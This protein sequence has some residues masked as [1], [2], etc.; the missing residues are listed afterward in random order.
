MLV[1]V[2]VRGDQVSSIDRAVDD[3]FTLFPAADGADFFAFGGTE[4][5]SFSFFADWAGHGF[6]FR[7]DEQ[8]TPYGVKNTNVASIAVPCSFVGAGLAP[9]GRRILSR[10]H[11]L[12]RR[13]N[14][15]VPL[16][17][18]SFSST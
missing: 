12:A 6:V 17:E 7:R 16:R 5:L 2:A 1:F 14:G 18:H 3:D 15:F 9:P 10:S 4:S 8:N 11:R 13:R